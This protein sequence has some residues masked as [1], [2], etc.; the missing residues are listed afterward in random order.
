MQLLKDPGLIRS[1]LK[2]T[3]IIKNARVILAIQKEFGSLSNHVWG[4]V[5]NTPIVR[6][7]SE[8]V[9]ALNEVRRVT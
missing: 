1:R 4:F 2:L 3:S 5:K 6:D 8:S 7:S 9:I